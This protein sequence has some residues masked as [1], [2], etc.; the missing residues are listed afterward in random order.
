MKKL[1]KAFTF[2]ELLIAITIFAIIASSIYYTL[3]AGIMTYSRG[4][5]IIKDNQRLRIFFDIISK[6]MRN[7][8]PALGKDPNF[9]VTS[10]WQV[11]RISFPTIINV[12]DGGEISGEIAKVAYEF[13]SGKGQVLRRCATLKKKFN[14]DLADI[15][16]LLE[17]SEDFTLEDFAF[18]YY[19]KIEGFGDE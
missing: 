10:E 9:I 14:E 12:S 11:N 8:I 6:D 15:E 13:D 17:E 4:N 5:S 2:I 19:H 7:A 1:N 3:N 16:I 18:E